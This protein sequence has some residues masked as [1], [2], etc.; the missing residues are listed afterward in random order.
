MNSFLVLDSLK[1]VSSFG[2][3]IA[4]KNSR[5]DHFRSLRA[6]GLCTILSSV[7]TLLP[8]STHAQF[9]WGAQ[10]PTPPS[11]LSASTVSSSQINLTWSDNSYDEIAFVIER[12]SGINGDWSVVQTVS[13]NITSYSNIGI[14]GNTRYAYRV[15]AI[16]FFSGD[17]SSVHIPDPIQTSSSYTNEA[18]SITQPSTQRWEVTNLVNNQHLSGSYLLDVTINDATMQ[19]LDLKLKID[20][21]ESGWGGQPFPDGN[22]KQTT[23]ELSTDGY[24]NGTHTIQVS[25]NLGNTKSYTVDFENEVSGLF[26]D[27]L[28][29]PESIDTDIPLGAHIQASF[30]SGGVGPQ[31]AELPLPTWTVDVETT[32]ETPVIVRSYSGDTSLDI[33]WDGL[34]NDGTSVPYDVYNIV[35]NAVI[36]TPQG[37][38][39][40]TKKQIV[41][42]NKTGDVLI[43]LLTDRSMFPGGQPSVLKYKDQIASV[44]KPKEGTLYDHLSFILVDP[45]KNFRTPAQAKPIIKSINNHFAQKLRLL[46]V[47]SHGGQSPTPFFGMGP[48]TWYSNIPS[49]SATK[50]ATAYDLTTLVSNVGYGDGVDPPALVWIDACH[51]AQDY[52]TSPFTTGTDFSFAYTFNSGAGG[53]GAYLGFTDST[54][55]YGAYAS[56]DDCWDRWRG[57][58]WKEFITN[59]RDFQTALSKADTFTVNG[60]FGPYTPFGTRPNQTKR[61]TGSGQTNF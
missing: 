20:G 29:D 33:T 48:I 56:P 9:L 52:A 53:H 19:Y 31:G 4:S 12:K 61:W 18:F 47:D 10:S 32:D 22:R 1:R 3:K 2:V 60:G 44:L 43:L 28:F 42:K 25:D 57:H 24:G 51:S 14:A 54:I 21:I 39:Q 50:G 26:V 27:G 37:P 13:S 16:G 49:G 7:L 17:E 11:A 45:N 58:M 30:V 36:Y 40:V 15:K 38:K 41:N 6:I 8:S 46:Y 35:L 5:G 59:G 55:N 23:F 34:N